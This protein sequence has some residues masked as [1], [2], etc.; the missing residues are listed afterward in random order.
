MNYIWEP[1]DQFC[2]AAD[3]RLARFPEEVS[4]RKA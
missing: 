3:A 2:L 4:G 1:F